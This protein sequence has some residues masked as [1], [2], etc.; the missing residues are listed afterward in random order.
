MHRFRPGEAMSTSTERRPDP[1]CRLSH[2]AWMC[3][4]TLC[5]PAFAPP[6]LAQGGAP[7]TGLGCS[8]LA[9]PPNKRSIPDLFFHADP[10]V[11][12]QSSHALMNF[13]KNSV[14]K[15][16]TGESKV[17]AAKKINTFVQLHFAK[18]IFAPSSL[19]VGQPPGCDCAHPSLLAQCGVRP[20]FIRERAAAHRCS[21][22]RIA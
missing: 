22:T 18:C 1:L 20:I 2:S 16:G 15:A 21:A 14:P 13:P 9:S 6:S 3:L 8:T 5:H 12:G 7:G 4:S 19:L 11:F 10:A 17:Y